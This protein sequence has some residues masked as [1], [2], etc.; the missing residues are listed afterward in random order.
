[1]V[2]LANGTG[3]WMDSLWTRTFDQS[4]DDPWQ[5]GNRY[6][7]STPEHYR[8]QRFVIQIQFMTAMISKPISPKTE[9]ALLSPFTHTKSGTLSP[10]PWNAH[11][12]RHRIPIFFI[13]SLLHNRGT[14]NWMIEDTHLWP[15]TCGRK[16][17]EV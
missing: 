8:S 5:F 11:R 6:P 15:S 9:N 1:M 7:D 17:L 13:V 16:G 10:R 14:P 4:A 12:N 3:G 2:G